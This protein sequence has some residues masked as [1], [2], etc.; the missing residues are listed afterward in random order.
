MLSNVDAAASRCLV[1]G[2]GGT[3]KRKRFI[4]ID[5]SASSGV[6]SRIRGSII[7]YRNIVHGTN[8][9]IIHSAAVMCYRIFFN[10]G[11]FNGYRPEAV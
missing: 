9:R 6:G 2:N 1:V 8:T 3:G 7:L 10:F 4:A 11:I 5:S